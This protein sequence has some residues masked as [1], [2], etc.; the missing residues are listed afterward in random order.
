MF[1][2]IYKSYFTKQEFILIHTNVFLINIFLVLIIYFL[3]TGFLLVYN[4]FYLENMLS[5]FKD[6]T[7]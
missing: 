5:K 6:N 1:L 3:R 4:L 7:H 2:A